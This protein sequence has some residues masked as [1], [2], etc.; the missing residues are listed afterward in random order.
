MVSAGLVEGA[1]NQIYLEFLYFVVEI[2]AARDVYVCRKSFGAF[3]HFKGEFGIADFGAQTFDGDL[4]GRGDHD[5]AF[6]DVFEFADIAR[7]IV[8][9]EQ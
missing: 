2:Y 4:V 6:D 3:H 5:G 1:A 8:I 7:I 9:F